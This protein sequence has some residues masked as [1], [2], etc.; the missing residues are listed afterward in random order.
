ML[1]AVVFVHSASS[2]SVCPVPIIV[3]AVLWRA[4]ELLLRHVGAVSAPV[5]IVLQRLPR[6][7][8]MI[9]ANP[10]KASEAQDSIVDL[11]RSA[12]QSSPVRWCRFCYRLIH[13]PSFPQP[14]RCRSGSPF[15]F[16]SL[17]LTSPPVCYLVTNKTKRHRRTFQPT[18]NCC[19]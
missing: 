4:T 18:R 2:T 12:Y 8:I 3:V 7:G 16:R 6:Q 13:R 11:D 10:E 1:V 9:V 14:Y 17:L 19:N 5:R 15:L